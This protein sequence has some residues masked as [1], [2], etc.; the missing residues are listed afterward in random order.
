MLRK[1]FL[2]GEAK[3][4]SKLRVGI[5][6]ARFNSDITGSLLV[7]AREALETWKV[8]EKNIRVV[9]VP[10]AFEIPL[11]AMRLAKTKKYDCVIALGC[12]IKGETKHDEYIAMSVANG[13]QRIMLD[14]GIPVS[15]GVLTPNTLA[16]AEARSS[17]ETN[18]G[19]SAARAALEMALAR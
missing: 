5:V 7:G 4:A 16:Q 9:H 19:A 2:A 13:L 6:V 3:D 17:G 8:K 10:G 15:F 14:T 12:I 11:A 18:H 1:E